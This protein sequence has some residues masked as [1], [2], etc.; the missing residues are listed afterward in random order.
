MVE[1]EAPPVTGYALVAKLEHRLYF[2]DAGP[3][4]SVSLAL[5][6]D[7]RPR[8]VRHYWSQVLRPG[9]E[10]YTVYVVLAHGQSTAHRS[11]PVGGLR[12]FLRRR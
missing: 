9:P 11:H 8:I 1:G 3:G 6:S 7:Q 10:F 2:G 12:N 4:L 5:M